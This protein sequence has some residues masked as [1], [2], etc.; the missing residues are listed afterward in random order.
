[1]PQ[2]LGAVSCCFGGQRSFR[3]GRLTRPACRLDETFERR[4]VDAAGARPY[5]ARDER[6]GSGRRRGPKWQSGALAVA[7]SNEFHARAFERSYFSA[8]T[9][10]GLRPIRQLFCARL[11]ERYGRAA[12]SL[13]GRNAN[14]EGQRHAPQYENAA[15]GSC[16]CLRLRRPMPSHQEISSRDRRDAGGVAARANH[17]QSADE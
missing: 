17:R 6:E 12:A 3:I 14:R 16:R 8:A 10:F 15:G 4:R 2:L 11:Q 7:A 13:A 5:G 9:R 1:M